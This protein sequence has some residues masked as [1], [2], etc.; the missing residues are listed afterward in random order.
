[1][2]SKI[3]LF[4]LLLI[5]LYIN[6]QTYLKDI[7]AYS[8]SIKNENESIEFLTVGKES[9]IVK[10]TM[11]FCQGSLPIP[12]I[13][14][15]DNGIQHIPSIGNFNYREISKKYNIVLISMPFTPLI[16]DEI[17]L[18]NQYAYVTDTSNNNSYS[19]DYL[20]AN[21]LG[22]Y[23]ERGNIVIDFLLQ[24]KWVDPNRIYIVGHSQ[25]AKVATKI[26]SSNENI[27][28]LGF[29]GGNPLGRISIYQRI[30]TIGNQKGTNK[31]GSTSPN[32]QN[33]RMVELAQ[34]KH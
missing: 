14:N 8:F 26:A 11:I 9:N 29:L 31:R 30:P 6:G 3:L 21:Y 17:D 27:A 13:I 33:V 4:I 18:N 22:K 15:F 12:V 10:P 34:P 5:S 23:V 20:D 32:R 25:G 7:D 1:M 19:Q 28:A 2:K 24:Q 16:V